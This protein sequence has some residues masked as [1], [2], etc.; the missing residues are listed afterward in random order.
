MEKPQLLAGFVTEKQTLLVFHLATVTC[1]TTHHC[2]TRPI[3]CLVSAWACALSCSCSNFSA[4]FGRRIIAVVLAVMIL[5]MSSLVGSFF[6]LSSCLG[7]GDPSVLI[8]TKVCW[9]DA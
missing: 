4:E 1:R 9:L 2:L 5:T 3:R 6:L 8:G 7:N